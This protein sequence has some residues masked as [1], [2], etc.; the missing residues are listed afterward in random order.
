M[1]PQIESVDRPLF[2]RHFTIMWVANF[3][4]L[5]SQS[6]FFLFPLFITSHNGTKADIGILM[7]AL[8]LSAIL[9][10]PWIS[11]MVDRFGRK[12]SYIL[13]S[14]IMAV[15]PFFY[16][17]LQD[18]VSEIYLPLFIVRLLHGMGVAL[19]FTASITYIVDIIPSQRLNEGLGIFGVAALLGLAAGPVVSEPIIRN[20]GFDGFFMMAALFGLIS[21]ILAF[22]VAESYMPV[23]RRQGGTSFF[24]VL[25][26][27]KVLWG[28]ILSMF[29]GIGG[30]IQGAFVSPYV[31]HLGLS[32]VS[33]YFVAYSLAAVLVRIFGS[34][35]TDRFGE[36]NII[37]WAFVVNGI[38]F[39]ILVVVTN[40]WI[41]SLAGFITGV[42]HGFLFPCLNTLMIR[43]ESI[44]IRGRISGA[45]SGGMDSGMFLGSF[46]LGYVGEWFGYRPIFLSTFSSLMLATVLFC[47]F[48][49]KALLKADTANAD[50]AI[51]LNHGGFHEAN[52]ERE[53]TV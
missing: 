10:R 49:R 33:L 36:E 45:F 27:K 18:D 40:T 20:V 26:R 15:M 43:N 23:S 52:S 22:L 35:M 50:P 37:P 38:G 5:T 41:L 48:T 12:R 28:A 17:T 47:I 3:C 44:E 16:M 13:G 42:G 8:P 31:H 39:L 24:K 4:F 25:G 46:I 1:E 51:G 53:Q 34:K 9:L 32:T 11:E 21:L 7:A 19:G 30:G 14:A 2:S 29:M 6:S